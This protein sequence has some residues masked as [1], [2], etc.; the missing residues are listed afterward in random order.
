MEE[1]QQPG[2]GGVHKAPLCREISEDKG[3]L[4]VAAALAG[5]PGGPLE[6]APGT[7]GVGGEAFKAGEWAWVLETLTN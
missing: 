5:P 2:L 4:C 7:L 1:N 6:E 3:C